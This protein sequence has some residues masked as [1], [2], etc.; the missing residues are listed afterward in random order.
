MSFQGLVLSLALQVAGASGV[1]GTVLKLGS[2]EPLPAATVELSREGGNEIYSVLTGLDGKFSF[3]DV[4]PGDY[5]LVATHDSGIYNPALYR[6]TIEVTA[7]QPV[8]DLRLQMAL[9]GVITGRV[10]D[11]NGDPVAYARVFAMESVYREGRR[12][13]N[14]VQSVLS[15]DKGEYRLFW[16]PP[17]RY[18]V[19]ARPD[20]AQNRMIFNYIA[21]P[22]TTGSVRD[23]SAGQ[24]VYH[25]VS[26][27]AESIDEI[28]RLVFYGGET[29]FQKSRPIEIVSGGN[30][31]AIDIPIE[32]GKTRA[33]RIRGV[34]TDGV[35][36]RPL[37]G[38][39]LNAMSVDGNPSHVVSVGTAADQNG[40]FEISGVSPGKYRLRTGFSLDPVGMLVEVGNTDLENVQYVR[41]TPGKMLFR[42]AVEGRENDPDVNLLPVGLRIPGGSVKGA[43]ADPSGNREVSSRIDEGNYQVVVGPMFLPEDA[44]VP[45]GFT[46]PPSLK[47]A[48][49]KSIRMGDVDGLK[50]ELEI[51]GSADRSVEIVISPNG[52]T[53]EGLALS[54]R[55]E[56]VSGAFVAL[57]PTALVPVSQRPDLYKSART[58]SRGRFQIAAIPPGEYRVLA[59]EDVEFGAWKSPEFLSGYAARGK[60]VRIAEGSRERVEAV[61][62]P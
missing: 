33:L 48:Y 14:T 29:D 8:R 34:A 5:R 31:G 43:P 6:R 50:Q 15:N 7:G 2:N 38:F 54:E 57:V 36:G 18:Y 58:D 60:I 41:N 27:T 9:T 62:L 40:R 12:E 17:G 55:G 37:V 25:R 53:M 35:T 21:R 13:L 23:A 47:N 59:W 51:T 10:F 22:G 42:V 26:E 44:A 49:V 16:L 45:S 61:V 28:Y 56:P 32:A 39:M 3:R 4:Q 46:V 1:D 11:G 24:V 20:N 30:A 19:A 52:G